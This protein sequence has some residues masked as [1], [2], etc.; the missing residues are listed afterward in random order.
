M[1]ASQFREDCAGVRSLRERERKRKARALHS[2]TFEF[3]D[4]EIP[5]TRFT[6]QGTVCRVS[7]CRPYSA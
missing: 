1:P 2:T 7:C 6:G 4:N 3:K 5:A